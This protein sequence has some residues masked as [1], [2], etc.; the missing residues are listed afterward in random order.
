MLTPSFTVTDAFVL[1]MSTPTVPAMTA[2]PEGAADAAARTL[3]SF[4]LLTAFTVT[5]P[6]T[7]SSPVLFPISVS[8]FALSSTT[9]IV[10][11]TATLEFPPAADSDIRT[12]VF[13]VELSTLRSPSEVMLAF[14]PTLEVTVFSPDT[15]LRAPPTVSSDCA[16]LAMEA[17]IVSTIVLVFAPAC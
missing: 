13:C 4:S 1:E 9:A 15:T 11:P 10:P 6:L 7:L 5:L 2:S 17:A 16:P 3:I 8:A 12:V 14:S